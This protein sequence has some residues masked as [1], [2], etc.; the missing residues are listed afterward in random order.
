MS[1][2]HFYFE[3]LIGELRG[4]NIHFF[5]VDFLCHTTDLLRGSHLTNF[6]R[7]KASSVLGLLPTLS[8]VKPAILYNKTIYFISSVLLATHRRN[9]L[10]LPSDKIHMVRGTV[11][12]CELGQHRVYLRFLCL[13][14]ATKT[15][16]F[17]R[18][19]STCCRC[20]I[21]S[22]HSLSAALA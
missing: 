20:Y 3:G 10:L 5:V 18:F 1:K 11:S 12:T 21:A 13:R 16:Q 15:M 8:R 6:K 2:H 4:F 22:S 9:H 17:T 14:C 7:D 19:I